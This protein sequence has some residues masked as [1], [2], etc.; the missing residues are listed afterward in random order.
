MTFQ[1]LQKLV[2]AN[3]Q[4]MN[5]IEKAQ[6]KTDAQLQKT[7]AQ[8]QRTDA[9]LQRTDAQLEKTDKK[10][11]SVSKMLGNMGLIHGEVAEESIYRSINNI[12]K[13]KGKQ[14]DEVVRNM[15]KR[16]V[17]QY[18]IVVINGNEIMPIEVKNK[19]TKEDVDTFI[20]NQLPKFK[21]AFPR[22]QEYRLLGGIG[23]LVV[24]NEVEIYAQKLGLYVFVQ[25]SKGNM[26]LA[27]QKDFKERVFA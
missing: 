13:H 14:F 7:D 20:N 3:I 22:F 21:K 23:G 2:E 16:E 12:F 25:S 18:D 10:L 24:K 6:L 4:L 8:L 5:K 15:I 17:A 26:V 1:E 27:N 9:Q 19:L 11:K